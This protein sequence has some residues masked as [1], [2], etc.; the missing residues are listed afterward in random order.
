MILIS[1]MPGHKSCISNIYDK[2]CQDLIALSCL[3]EVHDYVLIFW[4]YKMANMFA[5]TYCGYALMYF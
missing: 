2:F 4:S 5:L 3:S 1:S